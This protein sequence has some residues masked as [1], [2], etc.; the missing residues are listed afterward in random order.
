MPTFWTE[1]YQEHFQKYFAKPF[2][3]QVYHDPDG[4]ALKVATHDWARRGFRVLA[5]MGLADKLVRNEEADFGEVI[6]YADVPDKEI[7]RLFVNALFFILGNDIPLGKPFAI[8]IAA[9]RPEFAR[10]YGKTALYFTRPADDDEEFS[11][12]HRGETMGRV[13]QA[14]FITA[15]EDAFLDK[16][17][18]DAFEPE[19]RKQFGGKLTDEERCNLLVDKKRAQ[20]LD[21]RLQELWRQFNT[22]LS[23]RRPS[24]V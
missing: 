18:A 11:Q 15:E 22:A 24:C 8:G 4:A 1:I 10:R 19:F 20:E 2:D 23:L 6:L 12:V 7:P 16:H 5:S 9:M 21:A 3:I 17:G 14:F 13:F